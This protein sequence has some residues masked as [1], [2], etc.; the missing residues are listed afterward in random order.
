M[1]APAA[2]GA[3][4][5]AG[6][7]RE[8]RMTPPIA[9]SPAAAQQ[10]A[11]VAE[12]PAVAASEART[13]GMAKE[14]VPEDGAE[15]ESMEGLDEFLREMQEKANLDSEKTVVINA[16][17]S[18]V[19]EENEFLLEARS[20]YVGK[21]LAHKSIGVPYAA[22]RAEYVVLMPARDVGRRAREAYLPAHS[23]QDSRA[24]SAGAETVRYTRPVEHGR[25]RDGV[26]GRGD[27]PGTHRACG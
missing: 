12:P 10:P 18:L 5:G 14:A 25:H 22:V 13:E 1:T 3:G 24:G 7:E 27:A 6:E 21:V 15:E 4:G 19:C 9:P 8:G 16:P 23:V 11:S 17:R 20:H 2:H 26:L